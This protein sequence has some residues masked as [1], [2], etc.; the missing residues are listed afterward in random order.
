VYA[1]FEAAYLARPYARTRPYPD[2]ETI[3]A[4]LADDGWRL[5]CVTNKPARFTTP[6]LAAGGL[7]RFFSVVVSGDS[8]AQRK[9]DA[10]PLLHAMRALAG[11]PA[12]TVMVGDSPID[13]AAA[14]NAGVHAVAVSY[15][16]HGGADLAR[17][18]ASAVIDRLRE[19][20]AIVARLVTPA[21]AASRR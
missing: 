2:V 15:G 1:E 11:T 3:L 20:P 21:A 9:P 10:A 7:D 8:L 6:V 19:L 13:L 5:G 18:G 16:Y 17:H 14:R 4:A 12:R